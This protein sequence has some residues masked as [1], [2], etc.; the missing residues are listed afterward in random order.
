MRDLLEDLQRLESSK[1]A[2]LEK[3]PNQSKSRF[4][5]TPSPINIIRITTRRV[6]DFLAQEARKA[7]EEVVEEV[8]VEERGIPG[9]HTNSNWKTSYSNRQLTKTTLGGTFR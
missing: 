9:N 4:P 8:A 2:L 6:L 7:A 1:K 3:Q 5:K